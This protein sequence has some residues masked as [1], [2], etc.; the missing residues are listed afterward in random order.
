MGGRAACSTLFGFVLFCSAHISIN[1]NNSLFMRLSFNLFVW[2]TGCIQQ[3]QSVEFAAK[4]REKGRR[5]II[6]IEPEPDSPSEN[7]D[8]H[9]KDRLK[10]QISAK[11]ESCIFKTGSTM[12]FQ[13]LFILVR[14]QT[15]FGLTEETCKL[16]NPDQAGCIN[17]QFRCS[18]LDV[19]STVRMYT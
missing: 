15:W 4:K 13:I 17:S 12:N 16:M 18:F 19:D 2:G 10:A 8:M 7:W 9:I 1:K 6:H 5:S 3:L 14:H 11:N